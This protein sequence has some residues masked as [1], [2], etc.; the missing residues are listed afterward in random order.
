[1]YVAIAMQSNA[2]TCRTKLVVEGML[3]NLYD[4]DPGWRISI[5]RIGPARDVIARD[6]AAAVPAIGQPPLPTRSK[7]RIPPCSVAT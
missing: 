7:N 1:M 4:A 2:N 5:L 3:H 6:A